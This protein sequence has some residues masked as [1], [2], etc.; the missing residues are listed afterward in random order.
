LS[1]TTIVTNCLDSVA[2]GAVTGLT[3]YLL[4]RARR[5]VAGSTL[6]SVWWWTLAMVLLVGGSE[7]LLHLQGDPQQPWIESWRFALATAT[8]CPVMAVL[9]ARR[10]T[11][12]GWVFVVLTLWGVLAL[13]ALERLL[14]QPNQPLEV[15]DARSWFLLLL[16]IVSGLNYLPT[17]RWLSSLLATAA[18]VGLLWPYFPGGGAATSS[19][20]TLLCLFSGAAAIGV[21]GRRQEPTT[22]SEIWR[23]FRD[24]YGALWTLRAIDQFNRSAAQNDWPVRL[25]WSGLIALE[26]SLADLSD[27]VNRGA[28]QAL[29]N[30]LRRFVNKDRIGALADAKLD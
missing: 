2:V 7:I 11:E 6:Q 30:L 17:R 16:V 27:P 13:P 10:P 24:D 9:G 28:R 20:G 4:F 22:V 21:V 8:I 25:T 14:L 5:S 19:W 26:G 18:Q 15:R 23:A 1:F 29:A 12:G 3:V